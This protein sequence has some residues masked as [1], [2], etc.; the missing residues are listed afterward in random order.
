MG[1]VAIPVPDVSQ[2]FETRNIDLFLDRTRCEYSVTDGRAELR[3]S[4]VAITASRAAIPPIV[5]LAPVESF[6][7]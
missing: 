4:D 1:F 7:T 3:R 5:G 6:S 2:F